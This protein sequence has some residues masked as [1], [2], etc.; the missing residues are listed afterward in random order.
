MRVKSR[1][2]TMRDRE[3]IG[4]FHTRSSLVACGRGGPRW[5]FNHHARGPG[6]KAG[7]RR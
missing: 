1:S 5:A 6:V 3:N 2:P 7:A 4:S